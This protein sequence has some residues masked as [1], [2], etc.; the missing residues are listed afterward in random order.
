MLVKIGVAFA[1]A[2]AWQVRNNLPRLFVT[3]AP[4]RLSGVCDAQC[5]YAKFQGDND[6]FL[7]SDLER[8]LWS[9]WHP[10]PVLAAA[11]PDQASSWRYSARDGG[12]Q[13]PCKLALRAARP[14]NE[15]TVA[16]VSFPFLQLQPRPSHRMRPPQTLLRH[17]RQ[18]PGRAQP[19]APSSP[20][21]CHRI[22]TSRRLLPQRPRPGPQ[23]PRCYSESELPSS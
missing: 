13:K 23:H 17:E 4:S 6:N 22:E 19:P 16:I 20:P 3:R 1:R 9:R 11:K 7:G 12:S 10:M 5:D 2:V 18:E 15:L 21:T 8:S 14:P